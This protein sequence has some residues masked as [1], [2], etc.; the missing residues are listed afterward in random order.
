[1]AVMRFP[2]SQVPALLLLLA[3]CASSTDQ[4]M[5]GFGVLQG[6]C[7]DA[8]PYVFPGAQEFCNGTDDDCDGEVDEDA[9]GGS[10]FY[11]DADGDGWG[12]SAY[13]EQHCAE[14]V[15]GWASARGDCNDYD[16]TVHPG[17]EERCNGADDDCDGRSDEAAVDA[18][19]WYSDDDGDGWGDEGS[20]W[21]ACLQPDGWIAQGG[22]CDDADPDVH[23][24][25]EER[26]WTDQDDDCD[27]D[28]NE[29]NA[30]GCE[31]YYE[32]VDGDGHGG[33]GACFCEPVEPWLLETSTDCDDLDASIH[34][35]AVELD[36]LIDQDCDGG[37]SLAIS[38]LTIRLTG[39]REKDNA[40]ISAAVVG[41][42]D[43][44]GCVDLLV[45]AHGDDSNASA[46]GAAY[47][48]HGPIKGD[49]ELADAD[50]KL[51]GTN[52]ADY[53]GWQVAPAGDQDGDGHADLLVAAYGN[54]EKSSGAGI[55]YLVYGPVIGEQQLAE[56][57]GVLWGTEA[58]LMGYN[59]DG[60]ED[61]T[62]D[63][64][65]DVIL[66]AYASDEGGTDSGVAWLVPGPIVGRH[67]VDEVGI[68]ILGA[69]DDELG[70]S[71]AVGGDQDGDGQRELLLGAPEDDLG[72]TG[73]GSL[74]I[75]NTPVDTD[76]LVADATVYG[77]TNYDRLGYWVADGGD[78]DGDG[79]DDLLAGSRYADLL[80]PNAGQVWV[81]PGPVW[82]QHWAYE[83]QAARVVGPHS[84]AEIHKVE[85]AGDIDSDGFADVVIG[86]EF[87]EGEAGEY[88][89]AAWLLY[90]PVTGN[91]DL[92]DE[93][94]VSFV[95]EEGGDYLG[96]S[97]RGDGDITGD[98]VDDL[99]IGSRYAGEG[100]VGTL[101]ILP[102]QEG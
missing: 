34:P 17:A 92:L 35:D 24:G 11:V 40:G 76:Y 79:Y 97:V 89:G 91:I 31:E 74:L 100:D 2:W 71:V 28:R 36:D 84:Y 22:D 83:A 50:A 55:A 44:D 101:F 87:V 6:D 23:P 12:L 3:G 8:N 49:L 14:V 52:Y 26:C 68:G 80:R 29:E 4:D 61:L 99:L 27:G 42:V 72:D 67:V 86:G 75:F 30:A 5:D 25:T 73:T 48:V 46:S 88:Q 9:Q 102:G 21:P 90:G 10:W 13:A 38:S 58:G 18:P 7:D 93:A 98:G 62:G 96:V 51:L 69:Y 81:I 33:A 45:G 56:A 15:E 43:G 37:V 85:G 95:S 54:D 77:E 1:M 19:L 64:V 20:T 63:G 39:E 16:P 82:G 41:D 53:A 32:D 65:P 94:D 70:Y 60:G 66:G 57:E 47:L 78:I 59:I